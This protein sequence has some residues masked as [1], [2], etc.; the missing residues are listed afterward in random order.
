[1]SNFSTSRVSSSEMEEVSE[2]NG[3]KVI[4]SWVTIGKR[5]VRVAAAGP[6]ARSTD[7]T[8]AAAAAGRL[9]TSGSDAVSGAA[10]FTDCDRLTE[11]DCCCWEVALRDPMGSTG[12]EFEFVVV[13]E[14]EVEV[15]EW[16]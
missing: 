7:W 2:A 5:T 3:V 11:L 4:Q 14:L 16:V 9:F 1:M 12:F 8:A 13:V 10:A 6:T 15:L